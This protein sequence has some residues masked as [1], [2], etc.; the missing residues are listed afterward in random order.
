MKYY[1]MQLGPNRK[2]RYAVR[3]ISRHDA[4]KKMVSW[5]GYG[6]WSI[7]GH[8]EVKQDVYKKYKCHVIS[9]VTL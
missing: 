9:D 7:V 8:T 4:N 3:A 1:I 6:G 2:R 5:F